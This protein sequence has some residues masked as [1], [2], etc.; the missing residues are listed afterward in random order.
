MITKN[1]YNFNQD[2]IFLV[3]K[4]ANNPKRSFLFISKLLGKHLAVNPDVVKATGFLLSSLKYKFE[5]T[6]FVECIKNG[7][8]PDYSNKAKD[9]VLVVGFC[10]TAT[11]L[12]Y[13]VA[14]SI[15]GCTYQTTTREPISGI[16]KLL[17]FEEEH[18]H[19][20]THNMFSNNVNFNDFEE[21]ILVDDEI[22]TGNSLLNLISAIKEKSNIKI[23][24]VMTI[25]DWRKPEQREKFSE[26]E[27]GHNIKINVFSLIEGVLDEYPTGVIYTNEE[28]KINTKC[29][30]L[31]GNLD[32]L[33]RFVAKT[34]YGKESYFKNSGRFGVTYENIL[35]T[36]EECEKAAEKIIRRQGTLNNILILGHGEN[37]YIPS[38]IATYIKQKTGCNVE[39]RTTSLSPIYCDGTVIKDETLFLDRGN[40]Y[41]FYNKQDAEKYDKVILLT[42]TPLNVKLC[43]NIVI[44][45]L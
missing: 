45:D 18:S 5:N 27:Q 10:E 1:L 6:S 36:E 25:L 38:R 9:N 7:A 32:C 30:P 4:R 44:Y 11:G 26:F 3:G 12:G 37:I 17:S 8:I 28:E 23:F 19:A 42:E 41:H 39:F 29:V 15:E 13:A 2:D 22:S 43:E 20:T 35:K 16:P 33:S 14:S 21:I 34:T 24:N 40:L 31:L